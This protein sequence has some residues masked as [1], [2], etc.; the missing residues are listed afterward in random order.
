MLL[1]ET[2]MIL[3]AIPYES[4]AELNDE[5]LKKKLVIVTSP[6]PRLCERQAD[7]V[8]EFPRV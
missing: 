8:F 4:P 1:N 2:A 3:V 5:G 6:N 7:L